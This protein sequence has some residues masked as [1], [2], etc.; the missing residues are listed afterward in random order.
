MIEPAADIV[1]K[2]LA[3]LVRVGAMEEKELN[4]LRAA[5]DALWRVR[6]A[7]LAR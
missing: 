4:D 6:T 1:G 7:R 5:Q 2:P 3:V